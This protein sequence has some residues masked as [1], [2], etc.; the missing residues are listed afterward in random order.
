LHEGHPRTNYQRREEPIKKGETTA[1]DLKRN[2]H[3]DYQSTV[4]KP[5]LDY[6]ESINID[7]KT[8][9]SSQKK[10]SVLHKQV[11]ELRAAVARESRSRSNKK[12]AVVK[13]K[14]R[15]SASPQRGSNAGGLLS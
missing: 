3:F 4:V 13:G 9:S 12:L 2:L 14:L 15:Q 8:E 11:R 7:I 6:G 5:S 10:K 1:A